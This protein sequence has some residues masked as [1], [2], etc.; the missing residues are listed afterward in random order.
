MHKLLPLIQNETLK[1]W[2]KK[3]FYVIIAI[4]LALIPIFTYAE[5]KVAQNNADKF[6]DWRSQVL[7]RMTDIENTLS[8]DR[9]PEEWKRG[10]R[11]LL[12]QLQ[13]YLDHDVDPSAPNA[14]TF[15]RGFLNNSVTLFI[16]LLI[17]ALGSDLISGERTSGTIKLL[18]TRPVRRWKVLFSKLCA[19]VLYASLTVVVTALLCYG[20]SGLFFGYEGWG[21]PIFT[22]FRMAHGTIDS[23]GAHAVPQWQYMLM[24]AG[25]VWYSAIIIAVLALMVSVLIRST[26]AS[27]L[28]MMAAIITGTILSNMSSSWTSAKYLFAVNLNLTGY[29]EGSPPPIEGMS[30]PFSLVVLAIWGICGLIVS[31]GVFTKQDILN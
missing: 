10:R 14:V 15:T 2:K 13:Y 21:L 3:R 18:L 28:T 20:I 16:P 31:F 5:L 24:Q 25:L 8:S 9:I 7:Q 17:L 11:V 23:S 1:I 30:L 22:G 29:L 12:G 4:L 26:A 27:M 19:L 6:T